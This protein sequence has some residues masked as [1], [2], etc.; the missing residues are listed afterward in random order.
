MRGCAAP[1]T[2]IV[3]WDGD[4]ETVWSGHVYPFMGPAPVSS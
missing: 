2:V 1:V 3:L 4:T